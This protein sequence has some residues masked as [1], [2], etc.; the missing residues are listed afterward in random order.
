MLWVSKISYDFIAST[1]VTSLFVTT[2]IIPTIYLCSDHGALQITADFAS[3]RK[4][5][6]NNETLKEE[7]RRYL[8][9]LDSVRQC[10]GVARLL[11]AKPGELVNVKPSKNKVSPIT[12]TPKN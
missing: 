2:F 5:I 1:F 6:G 11:Q 7:S 3:L 9:L 12:G 8:L 10:E 4:W